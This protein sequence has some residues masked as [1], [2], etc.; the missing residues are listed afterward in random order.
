MNG[1]EQY[2]RQGV[3]IH[4][5]SLFL[6]HSLTHLQAISK[7]GKINNKTEGVDQGYKSACL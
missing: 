2:N 6:P 4:H 7:L 1:N 5:S 3:L